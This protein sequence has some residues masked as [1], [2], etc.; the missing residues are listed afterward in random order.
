MILAGSIVLAY[1][2]QTVPR[3]PTGG[4]AFIVRI[5][6]R[7]AETIS[8]TSGGKA[9]GAFF[10]STGTAELFLPTGIEEKGSRR[11][12]VRVKEPGG[13]TCKYMHSIKVK[14]RKIREVHLRTSDV[15]MRDNQPMIEEQNR[16]VVGKL[17]EVSP[18]RRWE[19]AFVAP[20]AHSVVS[21]FAVKRSGGSYSYYHK[22]VDFGAPKGA[23]VKASNSGKVN[24]VG[25]GLSVY[26]NTVIIDHGQGVITCYFHMSDVFVKENDIVEKG[27]KIG[28]VGDTGWATGPHLHYGVYVQGSAV[29]PIWWRNFTGTLYEPKPAKKR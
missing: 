8:V 2:F 23:P 22:G 3:A 24:Y 21:G 7:G 11:L 27:K 20:S 18:Q 4:Q 6:E 9:F 10:V 16:V 15:K 26:G 25:E 17:R 19:G 1:D 14:P 28:T 5:E 13:R 12:S 29:D